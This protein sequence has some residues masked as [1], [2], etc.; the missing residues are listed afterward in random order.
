MVCTGTGLATLFK[1]PDTLKTP[2]GQVPLPVRL[3]DD[4]FAKKD[5]QTRNQVITCQYVSDVSL[6]VVKAFVST[7]PMETCS[8]SLPEHMSVGSKIYATFM[9]HIFAFMSRYIQ[10]NI[11]INQKYFSIRF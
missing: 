8:N 10:I 2:Q 11:N 9:H 6:D 1:S 5:V 4:L 7:L 3:L